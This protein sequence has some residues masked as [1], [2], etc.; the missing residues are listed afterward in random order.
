MIQDHQSI[1]QKTSSTSSYADQTFVFI[2]LVILLTGRH[3]SIGSFV[4]QASKS[5]KGLNFPTKDLKAPSTTQH[6]T[7]NS[8]I[9]DITTPF[10]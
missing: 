9:N 8:V 2:K 7:K 4:V 1:L 3:K 6:G 10:H 5:S